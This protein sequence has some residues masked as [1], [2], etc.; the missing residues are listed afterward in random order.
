MYMWMTT[1]L[2]IAGAQPFAP[3]KQILPNM[4]HLAREAMSLPLES[5]H[6][7]EWRCSMAGKSSRAVVTV[8]ETQAR[9]P[10]G[11]LT[12]NKFFK[13]RLRELSVEGRAPSP[14]IRKTIAD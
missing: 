5:G 10:T 9:T 2:A 14:T 8:V 3:E 7:V 6:T 12:R 1:L 4:S 11:S 13:V